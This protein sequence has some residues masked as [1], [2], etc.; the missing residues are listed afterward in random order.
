MHI[1]ANCMPLFSLFSLVCPCH[2]LA[3]YF[4][5]FYIA[6]QSK[7]AIRENYIIFF[8]SL[9]IRILF[10]ILRNFFFLSLFLVSL[11]LPGPGQLEKVSCEVAICCV[12]HGRPAP[13]HPVFM[14]ESEVEKISISVLNCNNAF[15]S[16]DLC[17]LK[18]RVRLSA[19]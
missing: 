2:I 12:K 18:V 7:Y 8:F 17:V 10:F 3:M 14:A 19:S 13:S 1:S 9:Y 6:Y 15:S 16:L 11:F 5:Y 4:E